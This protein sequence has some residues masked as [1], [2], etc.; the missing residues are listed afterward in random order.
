M[1]EICKNIC[2]MSS[3]IMQATDTLF[4]RD[5]KP[6]SMGE[7][8]FSQGL[9]PPPPGVLYGALRSAFISGKLNIGDTELDEAITQSENLII[10]SIALEN[11]ANNYFPMP[12]DLIIPNEKMNSEYKVL[13]LTLTDAPK[14]SSSKTCKVLKSNYPEKTS[15]EPF[16]I[17]FLSLDKY[18]KGDLTNLKVKN[19][20]SF[21]VSEPKIGIGRNADTHTASEGKLY[22]VPSIRPAINLKNSISHLKFIVQ[23]D[24]LCVAEKGW[25]VLGGER[26]ITF[27]EPYDNFAIECPGIESPVFKIFLSTPAVF[28]SGWKPEAL[29]KKYNLTLLTAAIDRSIHIGGW[30]M[31][32]KMPKPMLQAVPSGSVF[33]VEAENLEKAKEAAKDIHGNSI[34]DNLNGTDYRKQGFGIAYIGKIK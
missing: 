24:G 28:K 17:D 27:F 26:R 33:Y 2:V 6:F 1:E 16:Y 15:N 19:Q 5:G 29:L 25:M 32:Q 4:F 11:N 34:S 9:F 3:I 7:E 14:Y 20:S 13:P 10:N 18:L 12:K 31:R 23:F 8:T 22:R 21:L 30:D